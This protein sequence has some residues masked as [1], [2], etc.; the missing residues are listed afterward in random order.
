MAQAK[1]LGDSKQLSCAPQRTS[2]NARIAQG[3]DWNEMAKLYKS[4]AYGTSEK[5]S[6]A[7]LKAADTFL[8]FSEATGILDNGCGPGPIMTRI[9]DGY[10]IPQSCQLTCSDFSE[11]MISQVRQHK[12]ETVKADSNSPWSRVESIVQDATNLKD[13]ADDSQSHVT[14]GFVY[15]MT[16]DP[17]KALTE[18][19]RVL[20][21]GGVLSLSSWQGSQ[22]SDLMFLLPKVRPDKKMPH[23]LPEWTNADKLKGELEKAG[24]RDVQVQQVKTTMTYEKRS[25]LIELISTKMPH[26]VPIIKEMSDEEVQRYKDMMDEDMK[27]MCPDEP[28]SLEGVALV[29]TGR[30]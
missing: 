19:R 20:K 10:K 14:A 1:A 27:K 11:G 9:L 21:D 30:K 24:F 15:F 18:S 23:M 6:A 16:S 12:E 17:Q 28:G 5:P 3:D 25:S 8:P 4:M 22:W 2:T 26:L 13:I 7:L 29:A